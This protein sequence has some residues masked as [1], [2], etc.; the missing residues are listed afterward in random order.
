MKINEIL[1]ENAKLAEEGFWKSLA[2]GAT[3]SEAFLKGLGAHDLANTVQKNK[4]IQ[5]QIAQDRIIRRAKQQAPVAPTAPQQTLSKSIEIVNDE[6]IMIRYR[7]EDYYLK[8]DGTWGIINK[9]KLVVNPA[10]SAF[11]DKQHDIYEASKV[12][13]NQPQP[14]QQQPISVKTGNGQIYDKVGTTWINNN[15][16]VTDPKSIEWLENAVKTQGQQQK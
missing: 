8:D 5:G 9:P 1:T 16:P 14:A 12:N 2:K 7:N 3:S 6:P 11:L 10:M 13:K 15:K 4:Q